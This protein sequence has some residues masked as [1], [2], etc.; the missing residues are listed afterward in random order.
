MIV[1]NVIG[2]NSKPKYIVPAYL[3]KI[4]RVNFWV[5]LAISPKSRTSNKCRI[6][7]KHKHTCNTHW[8]TF[9]N[10]LLEL[11]AHVAYTITVFVCLG[12]LSKVARVSRDF[13]LTTRELDRYG[14]EC[15]EYRIHMITWNHKC[16]MKCTCIGKCEILTLIAL[17]SNR[18]LR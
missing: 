3:F 7:H 10:Y 8:W 18:Y 5:C 15:L 2:E 14:N 12:N 13:A 9:R 17:L 16:Y 4:Y 11:R 1:L 6:P